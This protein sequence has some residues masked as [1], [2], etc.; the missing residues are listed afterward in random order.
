MLRP[1]TFLPLLVLLVIPLG[2]AVKP[3]LADPDGVAA[4]LPVGITLGTE[5]RDGGVGG[6]LTTVRDKL[7]QLGAHVGNDG[8]LRDSAGKLILFFRP[9]GEWRQRD[10]D[11]LAKL[12]KQGTV[13]RMA[14]PGK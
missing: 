10:R 5:F 14:P 6:P 11:Q 9:T 13:I 3:T 1:V 8:K 12:E 7:A 4:I 2:C